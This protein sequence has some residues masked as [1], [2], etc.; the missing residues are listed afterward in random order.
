MSILLIIQMVTLLYGG[1][2]RTKLYLAF[3]RFVLLP[4]FGQSNGYL[5]LCQCCSVE[6]RKQS[7]CYLHLIKN[8]DDDIEFKVVMLVFVVLCKSSDFAIISNPMEIFQLCTHDR[9]QCLG[10]NLL[11]IGKVT[12]ES[13][14]FPYFLIILEL[15]FVIQLQIFFVDEKSQFQILVLTIR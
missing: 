11:P 1:G 3:D 4:T 10:L 8:I 15:Y 6:L 13:L 12:Q 7:S 9:H 2:Y 14:R 5:V